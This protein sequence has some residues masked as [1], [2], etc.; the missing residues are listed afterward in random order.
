M[1]TNAI[2][3]LTAAFIIVAL[4]ITPMG[5]AGNGMLYERWMTAGSVDT[6]LT[7][8]SEPD[9]TEI[10][11]T[12]Q[13][14]VGDDNSL[15]NYRA[16]LTGWLVPPVTGTYNF[17]ICTD[18]NGRLWLSEDGTADKAVQICQETGW[19]DENSWAGLVEEEVSKGIE[20]EAGNL[21]WIRGGMQEGGGGDHI[22]IAWQCA[23]AGITGPTIIDT[24]Y[25]LAELPLFAEN[26]DPAHGAVDVTLDKVL[27]WNAPSDPN[28]IPLD[29]VT[30]HYVYFGTDP[31][32]LVYRGFQTADDTDYD[33]AADGAALERDQ[34]YYWRIDESF[35]DSG[36][37]DPNTVVG[38]VWS[39]K[40]LRT[41]PDILTQPTDLSS[42]EGVDA[43][44]AMDVYN[45]D[46]GDD[47]GLS[48]AWKKVEDDTVISTEA[49][50]VI[51]SVTKA[52]EGVYYCT[53]SNTAGS[54][55]SAAVMLSIV[56]RVVHWTFS[57]GAGTVAT[58][59]SGNDIHGT[60]AGSV[61]WVPEG[62][63]SGDGAIHIPGVAGATVI[64]TNVDLSGKPVGDVFMGTSSWTINMWINPT[65]APGTSM[66]GGFGR[67]DFV[68]GGSQD[69]RYINSWN[70]NLEFQ[71]GGDDGFWP[72]GNLGQGEWKM[73][74]VTYDSISKACVM[75]IDAQQI[76]TRSY[77]ALV[78]V[79]EKSFKV[80]PTGDIAWADPTVPIDAQFDEFCV[81]DGAVTGKDVQFLYSGST[82]NE[83]PAMDFDGDCVVGLSDL[84][85]LIQEWAVNNMVE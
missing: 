72:G 53:V 1:K 83:I 61:V 58:D 10:V 30:G 55:D 67:C 28:G 60:V 70:A 14:G 45:P 16:R 34:V 66:L 56:N 41:L 54:R 71:P 23:A 75:Y 6:M 33:P 32:N 42:V 85:I 38:L 69:E 57:E 31:D 44:Y 84:V 19:R 40:S 49:K 20:L 64:A 73:L 8:A 47:S 9:Y 7:E 77:A 51:P 25:I 50:L 22:Q 11:P 18:D 78:D 13:W 17:W 37:G 48:Y 76:G 43:I 36:I 4:A 39:F 65:V 59:S 63:R 15:D 3:V 68:Q 5:K 81:Y 80:G 74:T 27:S 24:Q 52:D 62:G 79:A 12:S 26:P 2:R 46:T 29:I 21:Y 35:N 82:C